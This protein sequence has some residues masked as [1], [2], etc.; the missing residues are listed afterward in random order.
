[1]GAEAIALGID[2]PD[3]AGTHRLQDLSDSLLELGL[4]LGSVTF[5]SAREPEIEN[6]LKQALSRS[7]LV[8]LAGGGGRFTVP[9]VSPGL[10]DLAKKILSRVLDKRLILQG[11]L[12]KN[13]E[14]IYRSRGMDAPVG[15]EKMALLPSGAKVITDDSGMPAGFYT[16]SGGRHILYLPRLDGGV[17]RLMPPQLA[18]TLARGRG[19]RRWGKTGII[20]SY[21]LEEARVRELLKGIGGTDSI[22]NFMT[23]PEGVDIKVKALSD[24]P[25]KA[26]RLLEATCSEISSALGGYCY[27]MGDEGMEAAVAKLLKEKGLTISTAE[28]CTG[29]LIAKRLTDIPGSSRYMERGV[30]TYSN[31]SKEEMLNVPARTIIETGAVSKET[32]K[33]MAEGVRWAA[34]TDLGISVTGIAGPEGGTVAKPVGLVYIGL[35]APDGVNVKGFNF[36]GSR[37]SIRFSA[38]Q[39]ALDI[40]RRYLIS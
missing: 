35:A 34:K 33:A 3:A 31:H 26:E 24:T 7:F 8:I 30:V 12:L 15:F 23:S 13:L 2:V 36:I 17:A 28:S 11:E 25:D 14:G 16:E 1:L 18:R 6:A 10:E 37:D 40:L 20:R 39:R 21:G 27:G 4:E 32:A 38:S 22:I 5:V 29:G 9:Q 19:I